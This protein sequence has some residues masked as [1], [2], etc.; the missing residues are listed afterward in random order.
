[1]EYYMLSEE[2][3]SAL[4]FLRPKGAGA[5]TTDREV[6]HLKAKVNQMSHHEGFLRNFLVGGAHALCPNDPEVARQIDGI[7]MLTDI[8]RRLSPSGQIV[9]AQ[10]ILNDVEHQIRTASPEERALQG[11]LYG[12]PR[13]SQAA[14]LDRIER[15]L[16]GKPTLADWTDVRRLIEQDRVKLEGHLPQLLEQYRLGYLPDEARV[17]EV[18]KRLRKILKQPGIPPQTGQWLNQQLQAAVDMRGYIANQDPLP[19]WMQ[20]EI[21]RTYRL[22]GFAVGRPS[23]VADFTGKTESLR[24]PVS[25]Q[26]PDV[27]NPGQRKRYTAFVEFSGI[28]GGDGNARVVF[29]DALKADLTLQAQRSGLL[30]SVVFDDHAMSILGAVRLALEGQSEPKEFANAAIG[31]ALQS[32]PQGRLAMLVKESIETLGM[33]DVSSVS[34]DAGQTG[35]SVLERLRSRSSSGMSMN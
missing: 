34:P 28:D 8:L 32:T 17:F 3:R 14:V 19:V 12:T 13:E 23:E 11:V 6:A 27:S 25:F 26:L 1:M 9:E 24:L 18:E 10:K 35:A 22:E 15:A 33:K 16:Q 31:M 7:L 29:S 5:L 2:Q 21:A 4:E 20:Q 30:P